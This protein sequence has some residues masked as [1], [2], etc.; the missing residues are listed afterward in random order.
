MARSAGSAGTI[1]IQMVRWLSGLERLKKL[2]L[3]LQASNDGAMKTGCIRFQ[4]HTTISDPA[5]QPLSW[6]RK[7]ATQ[8]LL[9]QD[10]FML[11]TG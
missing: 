1:C 11:T 9:R 8:V 10:G 4:M 7:S 6:Q 3:L 2:L 5:V